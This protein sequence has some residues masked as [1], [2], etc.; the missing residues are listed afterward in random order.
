MAIE[1]PGPAPQCIQGV[2]LDRS[3]HPGPKAIR[4]PALVEPLPDPEQRILTDILGR[5]GI[6]QDGQCGQEGS[7]PVPGKQDAVGL[8]VALAGGDQQNAV[9]TRIGVCR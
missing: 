6:S 9:G 3:C 1:P 5:V 2:S 8:I 7:P 4:V